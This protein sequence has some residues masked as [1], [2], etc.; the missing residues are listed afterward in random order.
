MSPKKRKADTSSVPDTAA[1]DTANKKTKTTTS[2]GGYQA[3]SLLEIKN[4][5]VALMDRVP[6]ADDELTEPDQV[7]EWAATLQAVVEEFNLLI[8]LV[9]SATYKWG[10]DRSGAADQNLTLLSGELQSSQEQISSVVTPRLTNILA[11]VV[12][13]VIDKSI[14]SHSDSDSKVKQN[15]FCQKQV[16][17][18]FLDLCRKILARNAK[19]IR[20]VCL[21][22]FWKVGQCISDYLQAQEKDSQHDS[23]GFA[24]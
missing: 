19:M 12:D 3:M 6:S 7:Y 9:S 15:V 20:Q 5:I 22:N 16:D 17:P 21:A 18:S 13:L 24:Y 8:S 10:S 1:A 2:H 23:R 14:I 11:P 4:R